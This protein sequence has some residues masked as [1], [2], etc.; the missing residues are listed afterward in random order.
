MLKHYLICETENS[1]LDLFSPEELT[2]RT[3][4]VGL[5][6]GAD[7]VSLVCALCTLSE[8]YGFSVSA[9][10]I[11][12]MIRAE[13]ADRDENF[14]KGLCQRLGIPFYS[15]KYDVPA[16]A[17]KTKKSLEE[18][19]RD[20]R[21]SYFSELC[22][23]GIADYIATAHTASDNAETLLFNII[24]GCGISGLCAIP[25]KRGR[26]IRPLLSLSRQDIED[27][28]SFIGED[29]VTDSTNLVCDCSR[30]IIRH[31]VIPVLC[32]INPSF[33]RQATK[34][35]EL[36]ARENDYLDRIA[37]E[38]MTEDINELSKLD[39]VILSRII[40]ILYKEKTGYLPGMN[41][42]DT[43]CD[44][45]YK[46][47]KSRS[48]EKKSFS[49]PGNITVGFECGKLK[50]SVGDKDKEAYSEYNFELSEG[51]T[52]FC[53]GE[54]LVV[55]SNKDEINE[56]FVN[57]IEYNQNIYSLF[58]QTKLF[59]DIIRGKICLRSGLPGDKI[60]IS[61]MS[62]DIKK[63]YSAKKIPTTLRK[64]LP[65]IIDS[66][67]NEILSLPYV[68]L[69]DAQI[70]HSEKADIFIKLYKLCNKE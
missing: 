20:I 65:R 47:A 38:S 35:S 28:L 36:A 30:N 68:G 32:E 7:S 45:I 22:D 13:E 21:Y 51:I 58:M 56:N 15:K 70:R 25:K 49:F 37:K 26:I 64:Y 23:S 50:V 33:H 40:G 29:Y 59:S 61:D 55:C 19:A 12:H 9:C 53:N 60:R 54:M 66:E 43:V 11:N 6:G 5:S 3:I 46:A 62:K 27:Y 24:R 69:C 4:L 42:I 17:K 57:Q 67:T 41:H 63:M 48:G 2:D 39:R 1:L 44:E 8:K 10:H 14:A 34:L 52:P 16:I 31:K 18:A